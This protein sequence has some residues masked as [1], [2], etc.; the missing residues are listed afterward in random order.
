MR[1][2]KF[3]ASI[4]LILTSLLLISSVAVAQ[5]DAKKKWEFVVAPYLYAPT[6]D[7]NVTI[8]R[9]E[10]SLQKKLNLGGLLGFEASNSK[11]TFYTDLLFVGFNT[12]VTVP[13]SQRTGDLQVSSTF[14]GIYGMVRV[15]KWLDLGIGGRLAI[16][17]LR[18]RLDESGFLP[19]LSE[20]TNFWMFPPLLAYRFNLLENDHWSVGIAGDIGGFGFFDTWTYLLNPY[21]NY[22]FSDLF[23]LSTRYRVLSLDQEEEDGGD[24]TDLTFYGPE[25]GLLFHF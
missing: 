1:I 21:V 22:R 15:A 19:E 6:I 3:E 12:D 20:E 25:I 16:Y 23:E 18:L 4:L 24:K 7:G 8:G 14:I 11:W 13:L 17:T 10:V 2:N 5:D 9:N